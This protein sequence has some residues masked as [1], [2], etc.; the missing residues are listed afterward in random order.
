M[1]SDNK[2]KSF[3]LI[4]EDDE[5]ISK[6]IQVVLEAAGYETAVAENGEAAKIQLLERKP[7]VMT[8][9]I[10]MPGLSGLELLDQLYG[11]DLVSD[12]KIILISGQPEE[13]LVQG[14][15]SGVDWVMQKPIDFI[16]V[17]EIVEKLLS[18]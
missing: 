3:V 16:A 4:V 2:D 18:S 15:V 8:L 1:S 7:D 11:S 5:D 12:V 10:N 14:V 17:A 13:A 9:D 6:G